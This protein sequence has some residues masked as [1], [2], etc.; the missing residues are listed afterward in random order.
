LPTIEKRTFIKRINFLNKWDVSIVIVII[1]II[2][3]SSNSNIRNDVL[4]LFYVNALFHVVG[5]KAHIRTLSEIFTKI[6]AK[7]VLC[8]L[9]S[10]I[11]QKM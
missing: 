4:K 10:K 1:V 8:I 2:I 6:S 11:L 5:E 7:I 3:I 9:S